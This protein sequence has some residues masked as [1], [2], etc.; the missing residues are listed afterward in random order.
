M[1][2]MAVTVAIAITVLTAAAVTVFA[3]TAVTVA[4][5]DVAVLEELNA[6]TARSSEENAL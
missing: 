1:V 4:S 6:L 5:A 2:V 3:I